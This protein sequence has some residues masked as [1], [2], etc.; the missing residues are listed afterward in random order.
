M[1]EVFALEIG[2]G[3]I[4]GSSGVAALSESGRRLE[5]A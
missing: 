5:A 1:G 4:V 2:D 3:V